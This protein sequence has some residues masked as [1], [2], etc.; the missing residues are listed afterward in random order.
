MGIFKSKLA[1]LLYQS[2]RAS[3]GECRC[4]S[5]LFLQVSC[6]LPDLSEAAAIFP[7]WLSLPP[8]VSPFHS[9]SSQLHSIISL[10]HQWQNH[11]LSESFSDYPLPGE[12]MATRTP[13]VSSL[14]T[15]SWE[16]GQSTCVFCTCLVLSTHK[17]LLILCSSLRMPTCS[18]H[19]F[20]SPTILLL[21]A[22]PLLW[23]EMASPQKTLLENKVFTNDQV[24]MRS[25]GWV[26]IQ[27]DWCPYKK[28]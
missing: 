4:P 25:L 22:Y 28:G 13:I 1:V 15:C 14:E 7:L 23:I 2:W 19:C 16:A 6:L 24:R 8:P 21:K 20:P 27:Y 11:A 12:W 26:L 3:E 10:K 17:S 5:P 9:S 18:T